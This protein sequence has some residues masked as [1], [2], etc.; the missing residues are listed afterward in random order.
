MEEHSI[1]PDFEVPPAAS[2]EFVQED[3]QEIREEEL[4]PEI[5]LSSSNVKGNKLKQNFGSKRR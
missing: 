5:K 2:V 1:A 3:K 4:L